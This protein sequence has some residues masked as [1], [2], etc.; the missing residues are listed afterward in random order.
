MNHFLAE[1]SNSAHI[2]TRARAF[3]PLNWTAQTAARR[4][5]WRQQALMALAS[6]GLAIAVAVVPANAQAQAAPT[7]FTFKNVNMQG[8]GYVTGIV[9]H[10]KSPFT[11]YLRT[12]VGGVYRY[13]GTSGKWLNLSDKY[14][15]AESEAL[16]VESVA[17]DTVNVNRVWKAAPLGRALSAD[18]NGTDFKGEVHVS[19]DRGATWRTTG[20]AAK[21]VVMEGN[22]DF[23]GMAGERLL[24]DPFDPER[25]YFGSRQQ[26]L[27]VRSGGSVG[28]QGTWA[29]AAGIPTNA[30]E[31]GV[32]FVVADRSAGA[33]NGH[34]KTLYAGVYNSGVWKSVDGGGTWRLAVG[35]PNGYPLR[36]AV[37]ATGALFVTFGGDEGGKWND[38]KINGGVWRYS[39]GAAGVWKDMRPGDNGTFSGIAID[40]TNPQNIVVARGS[41]RVIFRSNTGGE[42]WTEVAKTLISQEPAYYPKPRPSN[43]NSNVGEWGNAGLAFD[44]SIPGSLWQTNGFGVITTNNIFAPSVSWA[45]VMNGLEEMVVRMVKAP[46]LQTIPGTNEPGAELVS[47]V[48]DMI[49]FRHAKVDDVPTSTLAPI[50]FVSGGNSIDYVGQQPQYMAYVGWD[51]DKG[52]WWAVRTGYSTDNGKTFTPFASTSPGS[53]GMIALSATNP[54]N[55]VWAPTRWAKP[56]YTLDRGKTW[57]KALLTD[58]TE[59]PASWKLQNEWWTGQVMVADR[60][61]ANRFYYFDGDRF[62][63][64]SDGGK[65]WKWNGQSGQT[66]GF[67]PFWTLDTNIVVNPEVPGQ[68]FMTFAPNRNQFESFKMFRSDDYGATFKP[69]TTASEVNRL[70]FGRGDA[71]GV[72][73]MFIHGRVG[74]A[75]KDGIY[76]SKDTGNT[77]ELVSSPDE[78]QFG[79]VSTMAADLLKKNRVYI[80]TSGRGIFV[81]TGSTV[82]QGYTL[83]VNTGGAAAAP[84]RADDGFTGGY[85]FT[86]NKPIDRGQVEKPAPEPVYQSERF[87]NSFTYRSPVLAEGRRYLVR[88]HFAEIWWGIDGLGGSGTGVGSRVFDVTIS[89]LREP[90]KKVLTNFDIFKEAGGANKAIVRE[91]EAYSDGTGNINFKFE[92]TASSPDRNAKISGIELIELGF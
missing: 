45:W 37:S 15:R 11:R 10:E 59:L 67:A 26:G 28:T 60:V 36:A 47:A 57:Q 84:Y 31:P 30:A 22:G 7:P 82:P 8:M 83:A 16:D 65:T 43:Y 53:G 76:R 9:I 89:N 13:D 91:F 52:G 66:I 63:T 64:S 73:Y 40:P 79:R 18:G 17:V 27:W 86:T 3:S 23:R 85:S 6:V 50:D 5:P 32:T 33:L 14:S 71:A 48:A 51:Q 61:E 70:A 90:G 34:A 42:S 4:W 21:N 35:S 88:L 87:G 38:Q 41:G 80:G 49:G 54:D 39:G 24:V 75:T 78:N 56:Q 25:V 20:L 12:D 92:A 1:R 68:V 55:M 62:Y 69:V 81:G 19:D 44:P 2:E 29:Q 77:W 46:P 58:G 74:G 72:P